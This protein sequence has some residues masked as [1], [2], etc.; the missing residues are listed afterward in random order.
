MSPVDLLHQESN[1]SPIF[2]QRGVSAIT[3]GDCVDVART[4]AG[5]ILTLDYGEGLLPRRESPILSQI[6]ILAHT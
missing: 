1:D 3:V 6:Q 5:P 4:P 2:A